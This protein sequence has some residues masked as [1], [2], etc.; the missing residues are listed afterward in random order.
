M[1]EHLKRVFGWQ[2]EDAAP[3]HRAMLIESR[4][5]V[6]KSPEMVG[7]SNGSLSEDR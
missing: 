5:I 7:I 2:P 6:L 1:I 3:Q 4:R